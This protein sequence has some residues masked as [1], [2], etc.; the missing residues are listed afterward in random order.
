MSQL[1]SIEIE[2]EEEAGKRHVIDA[3]AMSLRGCR[4]RAS[5]CSDD[6]ATAWQPLAEFLNADRID[7][8]PI[9]IR[10]DLV[11]SLIVADAPDQLDLAVASVRKE[12]ERDPQL[13][14]QV[15]ASIDAARRC[16]IPNEAISRLE[17]MLRLPPEPI[18]NE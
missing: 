17:G 3:A 15:R 14:P 7:T 5:I 18:A 8:L 6:R 9:E 4:L 16:G 13:V 10:M 11:A 12:L 1:E 2:A